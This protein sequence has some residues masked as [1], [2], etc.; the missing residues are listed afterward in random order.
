MARLS[1]EEARRQVRGAGLRATGPRVQVLELLSRSDRPLSHSEV[2][3]ALGEGAADQATLYRNLLRL[4]EGKLARVAS[5]VGGITRYELATAEPSSHVHPHFACR[6][7]GA[8]HCLPGTALSIPTDAA[9]RR[10]L[11]GADLQIVGCCPSCA[12]D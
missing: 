2:V 9:W 6:E 7:C 5:R 4:V 1:Q 8:V 10:A 11:M 3:E 12:P